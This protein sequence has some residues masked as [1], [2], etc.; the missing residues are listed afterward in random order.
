MVQRLITICL[1]CLVL[2]SSGIVMAGPE[3]NVVLQAMTDELKRTTDQLKIEGFDAPYYVSYRIS[4]VDNVVIKAGFGALLEDSRDRSRLLNVDLRV[5]NY[6]LDNSNFVKQDYGGWGFWGASVPLD[7]D[8][9]VVRHVIWL[10]TDRAYKNA[11]ETLARKKATIENR[12]IKD[13]SDDF[14]KTEPVEMIAEPVRLQADPLELK[15]AVQKLSGVFREFPVVQSSKVMLHSRSKN[16]FFVDSEG[17]KN[18]KSSLLSSLFVIASAQ[19]HNGLELTDYLEFH[20]STPAEFKANLASIESSVREMASLL[21]ALT[22]ADEVKSYIGPVLFTNQAAG[23]LFYQIIGKG[24]SN[25][26]SPLYENEMMAQYLDKGDEGFLASRLDL[27]ILPEYF[28]V[29][30]DPTLTEYQGQRLIGNF[31]VD[32]EGGKAQRVQLIE[33]GQLKTLLMGRTPTKKVSVSNGHARSGAVGRPNAQVGNLIIEA[34][35]SVSEAQLKET[36]IKLLKDLGLE[37]GVVI[38]RLKTQTPPE[39]FD[40]RRE[41]RMFFGG[42]SDKKQLLSEPIE[43]F[44]LEV[45][46]GAMVPLPPMEFAGV[47]YRV[48]KDIF[49]QGDQQHLVNFVSYSDMAGALP[50]SVVAPSVIIE[51]MELTSKDL[52]LTRKPYLAHPF[53]SKE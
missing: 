53:F 40:S 35:Q 29:Y 3:S 16:T 20:Y 49:A 7:D 24:V 32:D 50:M 34:Q 4:D 45:K 39:L 47:N 43:A 11:I 51:E 44:M 48:L 33:Q 28:S 6:S 15:P 27:R 52:S 14:S 5:G 25:P 9:D 10:E 22:T 41:M 17:S 23:Q 36:F 8:Y 42:Q 1:T 13:R 37:K 31:T 18:I 21:T 38:T 12:L 26:V 30:D 46:T 19:A 2:M